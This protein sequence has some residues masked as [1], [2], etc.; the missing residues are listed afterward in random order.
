MSSTFAW[1]DVSAK[2][3]RTM[4]QVVD[5]FKEK[6]TVDELGIGTIRDAFAD[7]FFPGTS[8]LH[9]RPRYLLFIAWIYRK[10]EEDRATSAQAGSRAHGLQANDLVASLEHGGER[11]DV[12]GIEARGRLLRVPAEVYWGALRKF[13]IGTFP[14]SREQ[15]H[16]TFDAMRSGSARA[17]IG[18][19]GELLEPGRQNWNSGIPAPPSDLWS[20]TTFRLTRNEADFLRERILATAPESLLAALAWKPPFGR[21]IGVPW[22]EQIIEVA[23]PE[24]RIALDHARRFSLL[25]HGAALAYN[26]LMAE[27]AATAG[28]RD[29]E[30]VDHYRDRI[31]T[32]ADGEVRPIRKELGAW[33]RDEL[34]Q[35]VAQIA[36]SS[37]VPARRFSEAW[38]FAAIAD[39]WGAADQPDIRDLIKRR[40]QALKGG[41]ARLTNRRALERWS[42]ASGLGRLLFRWPNARSILRDIADG[43]R[44][45]AE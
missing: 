41:L 29:G 45:S 44:K 43:L 5:L 33:R 11:S 7:Y 34:W 28:T 42:G 12:I 6:G 14:G 15:Y 10:L 39:P 38:M 1:L 40:E 18:E 13:Q 35:L 9:T 19:D 27:A 2:E 36:P 22:H 20:S 16:A 32:W 31:R 30:L 25:M 8:T 21:D 17:V 26:L 3:R 23:P 24:L 4:L 37:S